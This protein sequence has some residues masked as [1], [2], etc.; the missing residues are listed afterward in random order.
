MRYIPI[1]FLVVSG[2][3]GLAGCATFPPPKES[4]PT[5]RVYGKEYDEV[6]DAVLA[7]L[8]DLDIPAKSMDKESGTI[9]AEDNNIELV[10]FE[11]GRYDSSYC[12]CGS[13]E[14]YNVLR[15]IVG[16]YKISI[17][18][19]KEARSTLDI[20]VSFLASSHYGEIST[21][22]QPCISKGVFERVFL[23]QMDSRLRDRNS[24]ADPPRKLD[25]W[26]RAGP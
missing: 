26:R 15:S 1:M 12:F 14:Q 4:I 23:E 20:D 2:V 16:K 13:P 9:V 11:P 7:T 19:G 21:G 10:Q 5:S 24:P 8:S 25:W 6:W 3:S 22:W 17:A 18:G